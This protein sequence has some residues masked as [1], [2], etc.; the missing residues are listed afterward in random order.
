MVAW[1]RTEGRPEGQ[2]SDE[3]RGLVYLCII[4]NDIARTATDVYSHV[5]IV[6]RMG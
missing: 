2:N 4:Q 5:G 1:F 3:V 6:A